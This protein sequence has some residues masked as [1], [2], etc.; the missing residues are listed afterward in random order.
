MY[1]RPKDS[2]VVGVHD[3]ATQ[4][5]P[6]MLGMMDKEMNKLSGHCSKIN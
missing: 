1:V 3:R 5:A 2:N 6:E 4:K